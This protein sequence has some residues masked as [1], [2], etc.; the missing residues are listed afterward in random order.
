[1][2]AGRPALHL[3]GFV[4]ADCA[5]WRLQAV[6]SGSWL[7]V[8]GID[9]A[10]PEVL[11]AL[12]PLLDGRSLHLSH[13]AQVITAGPGFQFLATVTSA[14]GDHDAVLDVD[15]DPMGSTSCG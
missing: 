12:S 11:A 4:V 15:A 5:A 7:L 14:P 9:S 13:R 10:P 1:M 3:S 6:A 2:Q 8:E